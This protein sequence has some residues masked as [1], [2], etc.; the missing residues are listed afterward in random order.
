MGYRSYTANYAFA[1]QFVGRTMSN[2]SAQNKLIVS[3][4]GFWRSNSISPILDMFINSY[5]SNTSSYSIVISTS[6]SS[7]DWWNRTNVLACIINMERIPSTVR[8]LSGSVVLS[9]SNPIMFWTQFEKFTNVSY[10]FGYSG[11]NSNAN[12]TQDMYWE[13]HNG[14]AIKAYLSF[15]NYARYSYVILWNETAQAA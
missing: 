11:I 2:N 7:G 4:V 15:M 12:E 5:F 8:L 13:E 9:P 6:T 10:C 14:T 1:Q 3:W